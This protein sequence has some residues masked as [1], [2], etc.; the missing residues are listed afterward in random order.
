MPTPPQEKAQAESKGP[1]GF[2]LDAA[3][4]CFP[5]YGFRGATLDQ[6]CQQRQGSANQIYCIISVQRRNSYALLQ[7]SLWKHG[8]TLC[9][10]RRPTVTRAQSV[11]IT[12][13]RSWI[14]P[15]DLPRE[16]RLFAGC[17]FLPRCAAYWALD[18]KAI[19]LKRFSDE[20]CAVIAAGWRGRIAGW[21]PRHLYFLSG[22][23]TSTMRILPH[24]WRWLLEA[25]A[26]SIN[27]ASDHLQLMFSTLL[28]PPHG[29]IAAGAK[30]HS[31]PWRRACSGTSS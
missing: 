21:K 7:P 1:T 14:W 10:A 18:C 26:N 4:M 12:V 23:T 24:R 15:R 30:V 29:E 6:D 3:W 17:N 22:P 19:F 8:W 20:K 25:D 5:S 31:A 9:R 27:R 28:P 16:S 11:G 13:Q 2:I